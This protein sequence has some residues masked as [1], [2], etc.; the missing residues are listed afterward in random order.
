[1]AKTWVLDTETKGTGAHIAPLPQQGARRGAERELA[2]VQLAREPRRRA[3]VP[4]P[5]PAPAPRFR[6]VDV[7]SAHVIAEDVEVGALLEALAPLR[8]ALD[9][10]IS[11]W[12]AGERRWRLL[13]LGETRT[14][15]ELSRARRDG[16]DDGR[17]P[18]TAAPAATGG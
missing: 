7:A 17:A 8:S 3:A 4:E 2:L 16:G 14:L 10:R 5:A 18:I 9:V 1:V 12:V 11:V 13:S 6:L 15:W